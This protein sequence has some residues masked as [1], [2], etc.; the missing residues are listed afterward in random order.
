M[1]KR[2]NINF[3]VLSAIY[4]PHYRTADILQ[5]PCR[6][7]CA[8]IHGNY[9]NPPSHYGNNVIKHSSTGDDH[10]T[11]TPTSEKVRVGTA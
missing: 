4:L 7:L 5:Q 2:N 9:K 10:A 8:V 11:L 6:I 1:K 3:K